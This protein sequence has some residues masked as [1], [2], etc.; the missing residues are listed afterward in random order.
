MVEVSHNMFLVLAS[1][2]V[3]LLAAFTG[4]AITNNIAVLPEYKRKT[5]VI[6]SAFIIGGG[7][8]SMHFVAMLAHEFSVPVYYDSL[9]TLG[10]ALIAIL[11]VG[12]AL[13]MLHYSKRTPTRLNLSGLILGGGVI[14]MHYVGMYAIRG[15][16]PQFNF[17]SVVLA[18]LVAALAGISAIRVAY[19]ERTKTNII[20]G[21]VV[22]GVAVAV[23]HY[24]AMFGTTFQLD[25]NFQPVSVLMANHTLAISVTIA[26][27]VI[28]GTF[29]LVTTTFLINSPS[30]RVSA[31][32]GLVSSEFAETGESS[33]V[34]SFVDEGGT[35]S[36]DSVLQGQSAPSTQLA[37]SEESEQ[38][39]SLVGSETD[40]FQIPYEKDRKIQYLTASEVAVARA[41]GHYTQLYTDAGILF[42]PWSIKEEANKLTE[43]GFHRTHRS[44]L[45]NISAIDS[46]EKRGETGVCLFKNYPK[47]ES[48][49]V[50]R[51]RIMGLIEVLESH[52][53]KQWKTSV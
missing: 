47:L 37:H 4:L 24:A 49:P 39:A 23:V 10:S 51:N 32:S 53:G 2:A 20:L 7:I 42:C 9:Q 11:V 34:A 35:Q 15:M 5:L 12:T 44:Y 14:V 50:S 40:S 16:I 1:I 38:L 13:L 45:V 6:M 30:A 8:W 29:L 22:L 33:Q 21:A 48:V 17:F 31:A 19:G 3:S 52:S 46:F 41:D 18:V 27:F 25:E 43:L 36:G 28:C 26:S